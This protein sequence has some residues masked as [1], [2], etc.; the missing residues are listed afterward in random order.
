AHA[1]V[2]QGMEWMPQTKREE[3]VICFN[4]FLDDELV[5]VKYRDA[6][7]NFKL[8]KGAEKILYNLDSIR[9]AKEAILVEGEWEV[10]S[11]IEAGVYNVASVPN[12]FNL[13]GTVNLDYLDNYLEYFDN[14]EKIYLCFDND[15]AGR[16]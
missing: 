1:K 11:F 16:K 3:K 4:Y 8:Y 6:R 13:Q 7:K 9:L 15:E 12:G 14:K 5:N 2:T 10:L